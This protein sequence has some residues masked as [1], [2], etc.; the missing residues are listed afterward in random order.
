MLPLKRDADEILPV[1]LTDVPARYQIIFY[2]ARPS[3]VPISFPANVENAI[4]G[5]FCRKVELFWTSQSKV[6]LV[7]ASPRAYSNLPTANF[8]GIQEILES[9]RKIITIRRWLWF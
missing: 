1:S 4:S 3:P 7:T 9:E 6:R 5:I 8:S 2:L